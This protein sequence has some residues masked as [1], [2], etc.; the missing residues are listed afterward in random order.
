VET[1]VDRSA[2]QSNEE[3]KPE[4]SPSFSFF[5]GSSPL[6]SDPCG[7]YQLATRAA[8]FDLVASSSAQIGMA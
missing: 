8:F 2:I 6:F 4:N 3:L 5:C 7:A 1:S